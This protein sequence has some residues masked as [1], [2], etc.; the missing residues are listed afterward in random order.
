MDSMKIIAPA[1]DHHDLASG[2][3]AIGLPYK[4]H[5]QGE[6]WT[7]RGARALHVSIDSPDATRVSICG[8]VSRPTRPGSTTS[9]GPRGDALQEM[10]ER[11]AGDHRCV[12]V[13]SS[14]HAARPVLQ[15]CHRPSSQIAARHLAWHDS[16]VAHL[17][18]ALFLHAHTSRLGPGKSPLPSGDSGVNTFSGS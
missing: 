13:P 5:S 9:A 17:M 16:L 2:H 18:F 6:V 10:I 15:R 4:M 12:L 8:Q 7:L 11:Q 1:Q 14:Q 3:E